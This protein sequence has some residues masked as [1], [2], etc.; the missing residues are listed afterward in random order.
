M[1][2]EVVKGIAEPVITYAV[3]EAPDEPRG[4]AIGAGT[5]GAMIE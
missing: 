2:A 5:S 3:R 1:P 4:R